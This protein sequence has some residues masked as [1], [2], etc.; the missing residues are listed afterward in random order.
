MRSAFTMPGLFQPREIERFRQGCVA[1]ANA[2]TRLEPDRWLI[3]H[4]AA[5]LIVEIERYRCAQASAIRGARRAALLHLLEGLVSP[6]EARDFAA[7]WLAGQAD[8]GE[9]AEIEG[10]LSEIGLDLASVEQEA[11]CL[12]LPRLDQLGQL[13]RSSEI[14]LTKHLQ[15]LEIREMR[16]QQQAV[17]GGTGSPADRHGP[18]LEATLATPSAAQVEPR[19]GAP[20][21]LAPV[22]DDLRQEASRGETPVKARSGEGTPPDRPLP[23]PPPPASTLRALAS[24]V[25]PGQDRE[26]NAHGR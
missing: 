5:Q 9:T 16:C 7:R 22:Q 24:Q 20:A 3:I 14:R 23:D 11:V 25:S 19:K 17:Q 1:L 12:A 2:A 15:L 6:D 13:L 8:P 10:C 21:G 4:E 26:G 18:V